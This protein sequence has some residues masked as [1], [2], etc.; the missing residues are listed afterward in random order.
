MKYTNKNDEINELFTD[1]L[2]I[3]TTK[4]IEQIQYSIAHPTWFDRLLEKTLTNIFN[5][6][7]TFFIFILKSLKDE[8]E[9]SN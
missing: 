7:D 2:C 5:A 4:A 1:V 9:R 8:L 3:A 6:I